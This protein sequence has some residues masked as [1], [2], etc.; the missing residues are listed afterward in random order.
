LVGTFG[1]A[2][3]VYGLCQFFFPITFLEALTFGALA[4][5]TDPVSV[6]ATLQQ[7]PVDQ[8]LYMAI[9][10]ESVLNDAVAI[11]IFRLLLDFADPAFGP[12]TNEAIAFTIGKALGVFVGSVLVGVLL[13]LGLALGTKYC[14]MADDTNTEISLAV[15]CALLSYV[16][17]E[18]AGLSGVVAVLFNGIAIANYVAINWS[19][20]TRHAAHVSLSHFWVFSHFSSCLRFRTF[21]KQLRILQ[22]L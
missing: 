7:L 10:G 5:A 21:S 19:E 12:I 9:F 15:C 18:F 11:I 8:N 14:K 22:R 6:I 17:A 1:T 4:S 3:I 16:V 2:A 20:H 13:G